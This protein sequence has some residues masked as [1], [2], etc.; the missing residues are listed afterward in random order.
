VAEAVGLLASSHEGWTLLLL[1]LAAALE[2]LFPPFPG[3]TVTLAGAVLVTRSDLS[4]MAVYVA[5]MAGGLAG[6]A[7]DHALG[8]WLARRRATRADLPRGR[9]M[10][11]VLAGAER[12]DRAFARWGDAALLLNRFLPGLRAFLFVGAGLAGLP[13]RRVMVL[14]ALSGAAWNA[15]LLA[16]GLTLGNNLEGIESSLRALGAGTWVFL[17]VLALGLAARWAWR[18]GRSRP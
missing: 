6:A 14:A 4:L 1:A 15:L 16:L 8:A 10:T 3:D 5:V 17:G 13:F 2:Y 11:A 9:W 18:R 12:S 7:M